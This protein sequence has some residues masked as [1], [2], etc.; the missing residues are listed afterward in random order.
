MIVNIIPREG[1][2]PNVVSGDTIESYSKIGADDMLTTLN[3][4]NENAALLTADLLR[5]TTQ[6]LKEKVRLGCL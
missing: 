3:V 5:I 2:F 6:V 1:V 4:T